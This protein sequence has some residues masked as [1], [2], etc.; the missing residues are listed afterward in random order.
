MGDYIRKVTDEYIHVYWKH[1][2]GLSPVHWFSVPNR[3]FPPVPG[4]T[5][6]VWDL[7]SWVLTPVIW[8]PKPYSRSTRIIEYYPAI[9]A[10]GDLIVYNLNWLYGLT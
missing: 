6:Y 7:H 1:T 3:K 4:D 10:R 2:A 5:F 8:Y 9:R